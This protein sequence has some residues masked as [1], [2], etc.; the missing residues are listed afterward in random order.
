MPLVMVPVPVPEEH[1]PEVMAFVARLEARESRRARPSPPPLPESFGRATAWVEKIIQNVSPD[2]YERSA[3]Y[4]NVT[5]HTLVTCLVGDLR[6]A[7]A[8]VRREELPQ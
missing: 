2:Q 5:V 4:A 3:P 1:V 8:T 6:A 7:A